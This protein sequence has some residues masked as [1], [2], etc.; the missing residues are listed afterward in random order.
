M[1]MSSIKTP[2]VVISGPTAVGKTEIAIQLAERFDGEIVSADSRLIYRG[3]DI[4][5]AKPTSSEQKRIKHHLLDVADPDETWSLS[6]Y[7]QAA[8]AAIADIHARRKVPFLV[9]GTG[10]YIHAII[11]GWNI[12]RAA[13][14]NHLRAVLEKFGEEKG[15]EQLHEWLN[16][17]DPRAA[18]NIDPR[19]VRRTIR[20]LEVILTTGHRFSIQRRMEDGPYDLL[21]IGLI[22]PRQ[23]LYQRIDIRIEDM[24]SHGLMTEVQ[25]LLLAGW[26]QSMPPMSAI[27]YR[28]IIQ[29]LQGSMTIEEAKARM[30][31]TTRVFVRRQAN[32][33]RQDD[34]AILWFVVG[35][36]SVQEIDNAIQKFLMRREDK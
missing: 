8:Q 29:V 22:R 14:N 12:P 11:H 3:M 27:G 33:F 10:Q 16:V 7:Q 18:E 35:P 6:R 21:H 17:L 13:P 28:E 26:E 5:T 4:G 31:K 20:A 32:W 1:K 30:R 36:N 25:K 24:F 15:K 23:E 19:N 2:L 34:S 9:G